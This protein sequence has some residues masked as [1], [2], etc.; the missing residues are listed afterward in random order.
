[1]VITEEMSLLAEFDIKGKSVMKNL[2][3]KAC[4]KIG[5]ELTALQAE[6]FEKY[7]NLLIEWNEKVNLTRI[8]QPEEVAVK[9]FADSLTLLNYYD[10]PR[11]ARVIDVGTGAGFPGVPLKIARPDIKLTLLDSLNKRLIFLNEVCKETGIEANTV[12]FRAEDGGQ[13]PLYREKY[14]VAVSRAVARLNVLCEYCLPYVKVGGSFISMKGPKL[15]E[16][17][18]EAKNAVETLGGRIKRTA[19]FELGGAGERTIVEIEK[20]K[21]TPKLYPRN[22]LKIK[23]NSL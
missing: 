16:E 23:N 22:S 8:I 6:Q 7:Y 13:N 11:D 3:K 21:S 20:I 14:D 10:I 17:L 19:E 4:G 9:H 2:V 15:S 18:N 1:M 12:H 5:I